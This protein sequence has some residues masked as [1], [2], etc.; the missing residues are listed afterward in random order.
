[1]KSLIKTI[2]LFL[3]NL[4]IITQVFSQQQEIDVSGVV[5]ST[6]GEP[7][8]GAHIQIKDHMGT[9]TITDVDGEFTIAVQINDTLV[10]SYLGFTTAEVVIIDDSYLEVQ[11]LESTIEGEELVV[12]G[13]G[14]VRRSDL[15]G[16]ISSIDAQSIEGSSI[17]SLDQGLQGK[18]AGMVVVQTSGQPGSSS[19]IR[20]R[21]TSSINGNN[22][23]LYVIDGVPIISNPA[24]GTIGAT[25]GPPMNPLSSINPSDIESVEIL[26]DASATA[27]Y[28]ARGANGVILVTTK[29]G[30]RTGSEVSFGYYTGLQEV[31]RKIPMLNAQ[32][33][34]ILGNEA[35]DNSDV[36]RRLIYASPNN[37]GV[38]T[39]WQ[40]QIFET[41][42][43]NNFQLSIN[44]GDENTRYS[45][46]GNYF[47][48]S[49]IVISSGFKKGNLRL[50]LDQDLSED[51]V[52]GATLNLNRS[53]MDGVVTDAEAATASSI[54]SWA[55]EFNPGLPLYNDDGEYTYEN[56]TSRPAVG[57]PVADAL[58][59]EQY[60]KS[61]RVLGSAY[62]T[63]D[64]NNQ[65]QFKSSLGLDAYFNEEFFFMPNFLRRAEAS[66]GQAA[67]GDSKGYTWIIENT[68]SY[69]QIIN[70]KHSFNAVVGHT[71]QKFESNFLYAATSDFDDNRLGYHSIQSGNEKTL[72]LSGY[73][74]WQMQSV[75][76]RVN[77]SY[78]NTYLL[79]VSG[80]V[81][82]SSKFGEGNKYGFFP[83]FS[84]AWRIDQEE[85]MKQFNTFS[86]LKIRAGFGKVGNEGIP[87]YS[88]MGTLEVTEA[89]FGDNEI[90]KGAGP[91]TLENEGL[92]WETTAQFNAGLDI[93]LI[94]DRISITTDYYIKNTTD[95]LLNA[96]VPYTSGF[97][98]AYT[99][100]GE[101]RNEGIE[102]AINTHNLNRALQWRTQL[103]FAYNRN[104]ITKLTGEDGAG[105][106]GQNIL[107][108]NGWTRI[109]EGNP[110]GT[111]YG[112]QS[113]GIVQMGED[114][115]D[116]P[117]FASYSPT[118]GD[119]KYI[120]QNND[121]IINE[122][123]KV[124]LG[125][126]NPDFTFGMGNKFHYKNFSLNIFMQ[127]VFGND[128]VN[129]NRFNLESFD[130]TKNNSTAALDR[131]TPENPTN[132]YPRA[133]ALPQS[134]ILS[135]VQVED[136]SYLRLQDV[137][138]GYNLPVNML[139][140]LKLKNLRF[141]VSG[142]NLYTFSNYSGFDP[143]VS[144]F[145]NDNLSMGADYGSY[146]RAKMI[147]LGANISL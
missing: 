101:L 129:F 112:Y 36:T 46:S 41:A 84:M 45:I 58:Q 64:I 16:A 66:N 109:T 11:L 6:D 26:K 93:G 115:D 23:P 33:L 128:I 72:S 124:I 17:S 30:S 5:T 116:V 81:D 95:L 145:A 102:I 85:F 57:N 90:A 125:N 122:E 76:S 96:P 40:D 82:G 118:F 123:D 22:E 104:E 68:L 78:D 34:A 55:L 8:I 29:K 139:E 69:N 103:T 86:E 43:I 70:D 31:S 140:K 15:T 98:F 97:Q 65:F 50:N 9:G 32:Q 53:V 62:T 51:V 126:A 135:D 133:N 106:T 80:R 99:N 111:I 61:N 47:D 19:T 147:I 25:T 142:K 49:G 48:Q 13:Y 14:L 39:D 20:I 136:G 18:A 92:K 88:S 67:L 79:T 131:W 75:L 132:K 38:G 3:I 74:G 117:V 60:N 87:P 127:G 144:R 10:I 37:L 143:E 94:D 56:N 71:L 138:I 130:G 28:G 1:M 42:P 119:R 100:I 146:P 4:F 141:Y 107:G 105:I 121:G 134:N 83:S 59:T 12:V 91:G 114:L 35:A 73:S 108:I 27:I 120:D 24:Q 21:G 63:W 113:N 44:G 89:Y 77:Y 2:L 110:I 52:I 137:T 7:I 54:T